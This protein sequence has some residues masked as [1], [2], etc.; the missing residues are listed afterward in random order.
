MG[1]RIAFG[2]VTAQVNARIY[3]VEPSASEAAETAVRNLVHERVADGRLS[4][5]QSD[6]TTHHLAT[7]DSLEECV[8]GASIVIETVPEIIDLKRKVFSQI[9]TFADPDAILLTNTSSIPGSRLADATGGAQAP[10]AHRLPHS[11]TSSRI[12]QHR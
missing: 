9:A 5:E 4:T 3:D 8:R 6:C 11:T 7:V 10:P 1:R 12:S 2:C